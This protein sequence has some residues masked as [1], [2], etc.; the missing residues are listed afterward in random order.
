MSMVGAGR[1]QNGVIQYTGKHH[2]KMGGYQRPLDK[3]PAQ[4]PVT[5]TP[6]IEAPVETPAVEAPLFRSGYRKKEEEP[7]DVMPFMKKPKHLRYK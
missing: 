7:L 5:E 6:H 2:G 4:T 1:V 3:A